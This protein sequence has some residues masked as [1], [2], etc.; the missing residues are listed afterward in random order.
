MTLFLFQVEEQYASFLS[1]VDVQVSYRTHGDVW[2]TTSV[3]G[4]IAEAVVQ[5]T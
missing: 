2:A 5:S 3:G 1:L 4:H